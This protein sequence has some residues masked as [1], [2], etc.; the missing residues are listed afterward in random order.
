MGWMLAALVG[1]MAA[2]GAA[3][4]QQAMMDLLMAPVPGP[5]FNPTNVAGC[6]AWYVPD[7]LA[8][9]TGVQTWPD[10]WANHFD[11]TNVNAAAFVDRLGND[12]NGHPAL[13][14]AALQY[15]Q[16][17]NYN[18]PSN[19][20]VWLV[21]NN[22]SQAGVYLQSLQSGLAV[23]STNDHLVLNVTNLLGT[24]SGTVQTN[25]YTL[26]VLTWSRTATLIQNIARTNNLEGL[27]THSIS[28]NVLDYLPDF[29]GLRLNDGAGGGWKL[30]E[31]F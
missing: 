2:L 10:R 25:A 31:Y 14:I 4:G 12:L 21:L 19:H 20:E 17:D 16:C 11:A 3:L 5:D 7:D 26:W 18:T 15:L 22:L 24:S 9:N 8:T 6:L 28:T 23:C 29:N 13:S 1:L 30:Y 27:L